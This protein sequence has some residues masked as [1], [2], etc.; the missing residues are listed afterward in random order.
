MSDP[1]NGCEQPLGFWEL[2]PGHLKEQLV[3]LTT[4]SSL[5]SIFIFFI[6]DETWKLNDIKMTLLI[7]HHIIMIV[8]V[9]HVF[10]YQ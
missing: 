8:N 4:E 7:G 6:T 1:L 3:L 5:Q 9:R 10:A 2:K